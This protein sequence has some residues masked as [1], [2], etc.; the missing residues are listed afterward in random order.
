MPKSPFRP[1][2]RAIGQSILRVDYCD[3]TTLNVDVVVSS[4]DIDLS[5]GGGVSQAL[6]RAGGKPV[7]RE[8]QSQAPIPLGD[9]AVTT[10][11]R[12][13]AKQIFHAAVLDYARRELTTIDLV[14]RVTK[15]CLCLCDEMGFQSIAF[16][17][18]AT[19]AA[20]L[21]PERSAIAMLIETAS[22][23]SSKTSLR[24][25]IMALYPRPG[26]QRDILPRFY[27]QV[28]DLLERTEQIKIVT[29][30][31]GK[32]EHVYR[33]LKSSESVE[34]IVQTRESL[35]RH[36]DMWEQDMLE[37]EPGDSRRER[38]WREYRDDIDPELER[39]SALRRRPQEL[40][41]FRSERSRPEDWRRLE[42]EYTEYRSAA[43]R[44]MIA[45]RKRNITDIEMELT[46]RGFSTDLKRMLE[47]EKEQLQRLEAELG[48][49]CD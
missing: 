3:I 22:H 49:L 26:L 21:S 20:R 41:R 25:V 30:S 33:E 37:R 24:T 48:E 36:R 8:A 10:A 1:F 35:L 31:L 9:V 12:L 7:W 16:P 29:S 6:L 38:S 11:G 18:L 43:V 32:L 2:D 39:M 42:S 27:S 19:G 5:M 14:R 46:K 34:E 45:I 17:A 15:R 47:Y 4:D 44:G 40:E 13:T 28:Q 23:L